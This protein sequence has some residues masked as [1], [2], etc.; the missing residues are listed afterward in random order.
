MSLVRAREGAEGTREWDREGEREREREGGR[1]GREGWAGLF[2]EFQ[3]S[4][5][6]GLI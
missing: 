2:R 5:A 1:G 6:P 3:A 4:N